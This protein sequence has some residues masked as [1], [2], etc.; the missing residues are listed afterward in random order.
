VAVAKAR[1]CG[2]RARR[3]LDCLQFPCG[4][5]LMGAYLFVALLLASMRILG[6]AAVPWGAPMGLLLVAL[7]QPVFCAALGAVTE[8]VGDTADETSW[9]WNLHEGDVRHNWVAYAAS[10]KR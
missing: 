7:C 5:G 9:A 1:R 8:A 3:C 10:L 4:L 2:A 6:N